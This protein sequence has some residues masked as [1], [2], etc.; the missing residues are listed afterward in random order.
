MK[1]HVQEPG[2]RK[3][4]GD[5]L[6]ELQSEPLSVLDQFYGRYGNMVISGCEID[7][8]GKTISAGLV[9]IHGIDPDGKSTYKVC[10]F[11]GATAVQVFPVYLAMKYTEIFRD[12]DDAV[13]R[14]IA[15]AYEAELL[16]V[17]PSNRPSLELSPA[18]RVQFLDVIQDAL[19]RF[20]TDEDRKKWDGKVDG[21]HTHPIATPTIAGFLSADDKKK[22]DKLGAIESYGTDVTVYS[23][24]KALEDNNGVT[25]EEKNRWDNKAEGNHTHPLATPTIAGFMP[26]ADKK[27]ADKLGNIDTYAPGITVATK[28]SGM[29]TNIQSIQ[30]EING[31]STATTFLES[32]SK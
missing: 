4:S 31:I 1:R 9:A 7:T 19:H 22:V 21:N 12:Y 29:E 27:R 28:I 3:W 23:K 20:V 2:V 25:E 11:K 10:P 14:P 24:I 16:S 30:N 8:A 13:V 5:D 26:A 15:Y 18:G 6:L 17:K 32:V